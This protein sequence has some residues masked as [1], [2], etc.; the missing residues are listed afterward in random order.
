MISKVFFSAAVNMDKFLWFR[1]SSGAENI[2]ALS[3]PVP[4]VG[5]FSALF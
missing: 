3:P 5:F 2:S 4:R 1:S